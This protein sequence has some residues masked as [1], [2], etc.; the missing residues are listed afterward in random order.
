MKQFNAYHLSWFAE[1]LK[2]AGMITLDY[3]K[4]YHWYQ[5]INDGRHNEPQPPG[6]LFAAYDS[7]KEFCDAPVFDKIVSLIE[8][9]PSVNWTDA[10]SR[11]QIRSKLTAYRILKEAD[12]ELNNIWIMGGWIGILPMMIVDNGLDYTHITSYDLDDTA[13][14][15]A[16]NLIDPRH[17]TSVYRDIYTLDYTN[18][19][20]TVVNTICEHLNDFKR[21]QKPIPYGT[22]MLL[23]SNNM[24]GIDDHCNCV[25]SIDEFVDQIECREVIHAETS[26]YSDLGDRYERYTALVLK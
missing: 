10:L 9:Y 22:L 4:F 2:D 15:V 11:F 3:E 8:D 14:K 19:S 18:F 7:F 17:F 25:G 21:W 23:Q 6:Y 26:T 16:R 12:A 5:D 24:Y 20:G 1:E 13:N